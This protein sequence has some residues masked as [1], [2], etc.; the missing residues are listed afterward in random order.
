MG[1]GANAAAKIADEDSLLVRLPVPWER[2]TPRQLEVLALTAEGMTV[3]E[4][5]VRM[6]ITEETV[7]TMRKGFLR[8]T[9]AKTSAQAVAMAF[10]EA[11]IA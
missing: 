2:P 10:R 8:R 9:G 5:A 3:P 6:K 1:P 4:I 11:W 7:K